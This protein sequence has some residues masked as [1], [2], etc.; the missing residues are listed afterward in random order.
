M[1]KSESK[2]DKV[3][4]TK[5]I[6]VIA[7]GAMIGW[8]W[9]VNTGIWIESAGALG[10]AL[11]FLIGGIMVLFVGL[12]Y[13]ELTAA[14]PQCGGEHVF[15]YKAM[16]PTGS[17]IC[18]WAII[19]GYVS[20]VAFEACAFPTVIQYLSP[21]FLK[22]YMY[23]VAGFDIYASWVAVGVVTA[24]IITAI[25]ILGA[26]TAAKLQTILTVLIAGAGILLIAGSVINGDVSNISANMFTDI[27]ES[28]S[29]ALGG[30][31][32]VAVMTPFLF[33]GFDVIPQAAEEINAGFKKIGM[34]MILSIVMAVA[35]YA[36]IIL[37]VAYVMPLS[38]MA[39]S[40]LVTA[41]AMAYAFGSSI[42]TKVLIVGGMAGIITS[43]NSFMIGG[44]RAM[45][46][47]AESNMIPNVF[48]KLHPKFKTPVYAIALIG[49]LSVIAPF[50]GRKMLVWIVD[51][52]SFGVCLAY[53]MVS[54]SFLILR[55]TAPEMKRPY[56]VKFGT[57]VGSL[58]LILSGLM[59]VLYVV[60]LPF[61]STALVAEEWVMAGG[62]AVLGL[63]F[64]VYC[65]AKYKEEFGRHIDV[66]FEDID[67]QVKNPVRAKGV[68]E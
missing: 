24:I 41:D 20:V 61:A 49:L 4:S 52:G 3:L 67:E 66:E 29:T 57:L 60:P 65:K 31:L 36:L 35:F 55:K 44:S 56:K 28:G 64:Y 46:S 32:T 18:T 17:F 26:K 7:F 45:F 58:A 33:V 62:W 21:D 13:A 42:M 9:V 39:D 40:N 8:G 43:W 2:F 48:A 53:A 14:M 59:T 34:I 5:D 11:A 38:A 27:A 68:L 15:S 25:N 47:M 30:V 50:F 10:A 16:G 37:A 23:T 22:G 63:V 51:A 54:A 12:T 6:F 1:N 19:L